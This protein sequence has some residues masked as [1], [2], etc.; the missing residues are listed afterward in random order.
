MLPM[1]V[2]AYRATTSLLFMSILNISQQLLGAHTTPPT[3]FIQE[4]ETTAGCGEHALTSAF[5]ALSPSRSNICRLSNHHIRLLTFRKCFCFFLFVFFFKFRTVCV[6]PQ[7]HCMHHQMCVCFQSVTAT[8]RQRSA[9]LTRE[10]PICRSAW[11]SVVRGEG[12]E[13]A[14]AA[15]ITQLGPTVRRAYPGSTDP[16]G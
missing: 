12:A 7:C 1:K 10:W 15:V 3:N 5:V 6:T 4:C 8:A 9:T 14:W 16:L 2:S 11:T 13:S